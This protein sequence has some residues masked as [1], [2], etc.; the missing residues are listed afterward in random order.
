MATIKRIPVRTELEGKRALV[1]GGTSGI[2]LATARLLARQGAEAVIVG[3]DTARGR[4]AERAAKEDGAVRFLAADLGD[5]DSVR[6]LA[7]QSGPVDILVN[8]AGIY[9]ASPTVEQSLQEYEQI[10]AVNVQG[11]YFLVAAL[12]PHMLAKGE[13]A[14]VNVTSITAS[15]GFAGS[16]VYSASKGALE[17]L[18]RSWAAEFADAGVRVNAVSPGST[19]TE[20]VLRKVGP[21]AD[22]AV[23]DALGIK[24][25]A[26]P[27]E[28]A[29]TI[30]FLVSQRASGITGTTI[31]VDLGAATTWRRS[32]S[33][34]P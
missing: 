23:T 20:G 2:G 1:T 25:L 27:R 18:T 34:A 21:E 3:R 15:R 5:P 26:D 24:R 29:E 6:E 33:A 8:N 30:S 9:P 22:K 12:V 17:A 14:I 32:A 7:G 28:I 10:F 31:D 11:A 16:S 19:R 13:G 4:E